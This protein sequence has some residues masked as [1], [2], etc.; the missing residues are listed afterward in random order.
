ML[1]VGKETDNC[2]AL[3]ALSCLWGFQANVIIH[4]FLTFYGFNLCMYLLHP[5]IDVW[6]LPWMSSENSTEF[7]RRCISHKAFLSLALQHKPNDL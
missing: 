3:F 6:A 1:V 4:F 5:I 2:K 7:S